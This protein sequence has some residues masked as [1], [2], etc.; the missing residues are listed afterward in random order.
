MR[1]GDDVRYTIVGTQDATIRS[2]VQTCR[3]VAGRC[4]AT[5]AV[6]GAASRS[7]R[8]PLA[9]G[10]ARRQPPQQVDRHSSWWCWRSG[11]RLVL[12]HANGPPRSAV[13][14][15][16]PEPPQSAGVPPIHDQAPSASNASWIDAALVAVE[17]AV[18]R[19]HTA[20]GGSRV[21]LTPAAVPASNRSRTAEEVVAMALPAV[22]LVETPGG[23]G[24]GFFVNS[25]TA[26]TNAHVVQGNGYVTLVSAAGERTSA[27][28]GDLRAGSRPRRA[29]RSAAD[30]A[31]RLH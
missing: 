23:K 30:T 24:T 12:L 31:T 1:S 5:S 14:P 16:P 22:V 2:F 20:A 29:R 9:A 15:P 10:A 6:A 3:C 25:D 4:R 19:Q 27:R 11:V 8:M 28:G 18:R 17:R 21:A 13:L 26:L 7:D